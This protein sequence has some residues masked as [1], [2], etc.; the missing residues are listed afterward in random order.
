MGIKICQCPGK[1]QCLRKY[2]DT[3][4]KW[5]HKTKEYAFFGYKVHLVVDAQS[6]LP[7]EAI[8]TSGEVP[9][10][11]QAIDLIDK[12]RLLSSVSRL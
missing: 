12:P 1:C 4:A 5:G 6:Q 10:N 2:S 8:V 7:I 3:D 11:T 9:D